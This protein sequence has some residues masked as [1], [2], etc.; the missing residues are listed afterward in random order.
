VGKIYVVASGKGGVG[1]T[2]VTANV[3]TAL[4]MRGKKVLLIDLDV[5]LRNLDLVLGLEN[6]ALFDIGDVVHKRCEP[7]RAI[8]AHD[9]IKGLS[10][11]PAPTQLSDNITP[12]EVQE[13]CGQLK[14]SYDYILI[15]APAGIGYG[16]YRAAISAD[17]AL[18]VSTPDTL[19]MRDADRA[20]VGLREMNVKNIRLVVN[21]VHINLVKKKMAANIDEVI[22]SIAVQ[23]I[24]IIPE[25][26]EVLAMCNMGKPVITAECGAAT[27]LKNIAGRILGEDIPILHFWK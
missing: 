14:P 22:D 8:V 11:L 21:R 7:Q 27:A 10:L 6:E 12:D 23:L 20:A 4:A 15:D 5:G 9:S 18:L 26:E 17:S 24:G 1:K 16:F 25:N 2:V 13:L 19:S 3:G